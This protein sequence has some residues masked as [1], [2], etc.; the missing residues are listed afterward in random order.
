MS[1]SSDRNEDCLLEGVIAREIVQEIMNYGVTQ[2]QIK[3]VIKLLALELESNVLMKKLC[4]TLD[5]NEESP[6]QD[7]I[8]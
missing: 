2:D 5:E 7:L 4:K 3:K 6:R 1:R 8:T